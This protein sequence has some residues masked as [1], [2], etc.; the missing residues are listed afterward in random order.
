MC[1][2]D[3]TNGTEQLAATARGS[4]TPDSPVS[5]RNAP[6]RASIV[7][8]ASRFAGQ[9]VDGSVSAKVA[10]RSSSDCPV[11]TCCA[12]A[13][14][15][16]RASCSE[17]APASTCSRRSWKSSPGSAPAR[18]RCSA[19]ARAAAPTP[20]PRRRR[21]RTTR[22]RC[23]RSSRRRGPLH[24]GRPRRPAGRRG[25]RP[26]T[27]CR[28]RRHPRGRVL[29]FRAR[30]SRRR[31]WVLLTRSRRRTGGVTDGRRVAIQP[32]ASRPVLHAFRQAAPWLARL[33]RDSESMMTASSSTAPVIM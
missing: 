1:T 22:R 20:G 14:S 17:V 25:P 33:R 5:T 28:R 23:R 21:G 11:T 12:T 27:R 16:A 15:R 9:S 4:G 6:S 3:H 30:A 32:R 26:P 31:S 7:V 24:R 10:V 19:A 18:R 13:P 8:S 2:G 29:W